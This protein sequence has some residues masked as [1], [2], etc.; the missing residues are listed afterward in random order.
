MTIRKLAIAFILSLF[1]FTNEVCFARV[2]ISDLSIGGVY[3]NQ[4]FSEV[5]SIYGRPTSEQIP[6]GYG[7][8][9]SFARG[10]S[11]FDIH[12][13]RDNIVKGVKVAGNNGLALDSSGIKFGSSLKSV[14]NYYGNPDY[15][16]TFK[17]NNGQIYHVLA[18]RNSNRG[19]T[20]E[21]TFYIDSAYGVVF[22][23]S[24]DEYY[25]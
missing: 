8:I 19:T 11:I 17:A 14:I 3:L 21:L 10:A 16:T 22:M 1:I 5:I 23:I 24:F 18:Y 20:Q 25:G 7:K 4:N 9:Y 12:V 15:T 6:A 13:T 2:S